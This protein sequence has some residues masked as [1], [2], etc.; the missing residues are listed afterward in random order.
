MAASGL[1]LAA[2]LAL[3]KAIDIVGE[4]KDHDR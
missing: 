2:A 3:G 4:R 1:V